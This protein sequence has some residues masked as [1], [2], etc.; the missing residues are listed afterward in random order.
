MS[1]RDRAFKAVWMSDFTDAVAA[2][3]P[4]LTRNIQWDEAHHFYFSGI[5]PKDAAK[6]YADNHSKDDYEGAPV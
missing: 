5:T 3:D 2:L 4:T 1:K 6:R